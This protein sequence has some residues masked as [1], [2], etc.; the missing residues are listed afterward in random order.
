MNKL[1]FA[2]ILTTLFLNT[3]SQQDPQFA[4]NMR[5]L[6]TN[7]PAFA[8]MTEGICANVINRQQWVGFEGAPVTTLAGVNI[9]TTKL[10]GGL[11]IT[12][13]D[14]RPGFEKNFQAKLAYSYHTYMFG[15]TVGIGIELGIIN[16]DLDGAWKTPET[17]ASSDNMIPAS[18]VRKIVFDAGLGVF[19][20]NNN[21][22][23]GFS[24]SHIN[25]PQINYA[26]TEASFLRRHYFATLGYSFRLFNS[27]IELQPSTYA[28]FDGTK[29]QAS[30]NL[31][32]LYNKKIWLG[33]SYRNN[34]SIIP[35]AGIKLFSN[36]KISLAYELSLTKLVFYSSG[37]YEVFL[38]YCFNFWK[39]D[40][41]YKYKC[42]KYL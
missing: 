34:E 22:Y 2:T 5:N 41:K 31:T 38:G 36:L 19:Y 27:P 15:G 21:F 17:P 7:N 4:H 32:G 30:I 24:V 29:F 18:A 1:F 33:V 26:N 13:M 3:Y 25:Q 9:N 28:K 16:K 35:M 37:T 12:I 11:G 10:R 40:N 42:V 20:K 6:M 23:T 39:P 8:G 14:D